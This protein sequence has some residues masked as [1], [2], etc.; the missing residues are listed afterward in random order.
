MSSPNRPKPW[1]MEKERVRNENLDTMGTKI[2][3]DKALKIINQA[4][5]E[6]FETNGTQTA[7]AKQRAD[8]RIS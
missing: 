8:C 5:E 1:I 6:V 7:Q 4:Y 2:M 3:T